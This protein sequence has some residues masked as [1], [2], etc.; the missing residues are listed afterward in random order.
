MNSHFQPGQTIL[1]REIWRGKV[2]SARPLIVVQDKPELI[3]LCMPHETNCKYPRT[4]EGGRVKA[5]NRLHSDW[6]LKDDPNPFY[7]LR[8]TIPGAG[9]SV[10][11]FWDMPGMKHHSFYINME[12]P[13]T[14]TA[15]GYNLLDQWLDAIVKPDLSSWHW[16]DE[17]ELAEAVDSGLISKAKAAAMYAEG[18]KVARWVQSGNSP[19][20]GWEKWRPDPSWKAPALPEGW[21]RV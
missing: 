20:N 16:K 10:V 2:W 17:D 19:F 15:T 3:A 13:L 5:K 7:T 6:I 12:E 4:R 8:L 1:L 9:Y 11:I 14:R 21:D 18:E